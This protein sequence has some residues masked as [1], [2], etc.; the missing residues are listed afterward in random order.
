MILITGATGFLGR[1]LVD[2][3]LAQGHELRLLVRNPEERALPWGNLVE[4]AEGDILDII[5]LERAMQGIDTVIHA[6][7]LVS[8]ARK[9]QAAMKRINVVGTE[10]VV[11][12]CL[13]AGVERLIHISSISATGR[14]G[15]GET[16]DESTKWQENTSPGKYGQS[17]RGAEQEVWR[18][19]EEGLHGIMLNPGVI[20]GPRRL[21]VRH[22]KDCQDS[23]KRPSFL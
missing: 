2:E 15:A 9:K 1:H 20:L 4:I 16:V 6:A 19:I 3:L 8:F 7:A 11:D 21:D 12:A 14:A 5:A 22:A 18:G 13:A 10:R 23:R 17:K